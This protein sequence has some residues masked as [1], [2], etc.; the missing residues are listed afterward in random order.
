M[1]PSVANGSERGRHR[2]P[3]HEPT[4]IV[5]RDFVPT[6]GSSCGLL[7][8]DFGT[9]PSCWQY[10]GGKWSA[11]VS[12]TWPNSNGQALYFRCPPSLFYPRANESTLWLRSPRRMQPAT[13]GRETGLMY[14]GVSFRSVTKARCGLL[15]RAFALGAVS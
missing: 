8:G 11:H 15:R 12:P 9:S 13:S 14:K 7:N 4:S 6:D 10:S 3:R 2:P 5:E 1:V